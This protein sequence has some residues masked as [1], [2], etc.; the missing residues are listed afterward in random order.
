VALAADCAQDVG[1]HAER[2]SRLALNRGRAAWQADHQDSALA[3][4][5]LAG[6]LDST[7]AE[8]PLIISQHFADT[9]EA[10]SAARY[11]QRAQGAPVPASALIPGERQ[12]ALAVAKAHET[13]AVEQAPAIRTVARSRAERDSVARL[14]A[15]DSTQLAG[16]VEQIRP[17]RARLAA[18]SLAAFRRD[19]SRVATRLAER[20]STLDSLQ[21]AVAA[22]S[23]GIAAPVAR[24]V[25]QFGTYLRRF[26]D[27]G[28]AA[29]TW[30]RLLSAA[31]RR[32]AL[33]TALTWLVDSAQV[34]GPV[35]VRIAAALH[36]DWLHGHA[37]R[38][39]EAALQRNANDHGALA[40]LT[41]VYHA[42]GQPAELLA[43]AR[44]RVGLA[45]LDPAAARAMAIAWDLSLNRDSALAWLAL[46]DSGLGWNVR[47]GSL[48]LGQRVTALRGEVVNVSPV[49]RPGL[50]LVF[51]F[52][53]AR[54]AVVGAVTM[55]VPALAPG[56]RAPLDVRLEQGGAVSWRYRRR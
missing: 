38:L 50:D 7:N 34:G 24:P 6:A 8:I 43:V 26:P 11:L 13:R 3:W 44:R 39:A 41:G 53:D 48:T 17:L 23:S 9:R 54:G 18:R 28:D 36:Q 51:E 32:P 55:A 4:F 45:P 46:S 10:D 40:V 15:N 27:D 19:S 16:M 33:D 29:Q 56:A 22:D 42:T 37:R 52:L 35:L 31:G 20:R 21:R 2:L 47:P 25:E 5:R 1:G 30:F 49:H 14:A 12:A